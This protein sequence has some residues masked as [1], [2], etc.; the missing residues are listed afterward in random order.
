MTTNPFTSDPDRA[1][2]WDMLM[3]RDF[4]AFAAQ[5]WQMVDG[6]FDQ[7]RFLGI[8]AHGSSS[9]DHWTLAFPVLDAYR[10]EWLRQAAASAK[11]TYAEPLVP[12]LLRSVSLDRIDIAGDVAIA[13]KIFNGTIA[14]ANGGTETLDWRTVYHCRR[15]DGRWQITGFTGYL[16]RSLS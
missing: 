5:D 4:K 16:P 10:D 13:H 15:N 6:D 11:V 12:A 2:I 1:A 14:L 9:P 8:H 3:P 7:L